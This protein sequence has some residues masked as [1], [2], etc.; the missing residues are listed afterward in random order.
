MI[1]RTSV[2]L[3]PLD[4]LRCEARKRIRGSPGTVKALQTHGIP[5]SVSKLP[6]ISHLFLL[7]YFQPECTGGYLPP[8]PSSLSH[9]VQPGKSLG[10]VSALGV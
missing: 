2:E 9:A 6:N 1:L 7:F 3:T 5:S 4:A 10:F 8:P